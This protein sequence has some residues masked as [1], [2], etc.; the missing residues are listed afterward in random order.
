MCSKKFREFVILLATLICSALVIGAGV[1]KADAENGLS[2]AAEAI[3]M[4]QKQGR[5]STQRLA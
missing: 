4:M 2:K 3:A 1:T 5:Q